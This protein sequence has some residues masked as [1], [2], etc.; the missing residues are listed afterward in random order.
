MKLIQWSKRR[1][2]VVPVRRFSSSSVA[3][4]FYWLMKWDTKGNECRELLGCNR[5]LDLRCNND[6]IRSTESSYHS[7]QDSRLIFIRFLL[8][9]GEVRRKI[10][11]YTFHGLMI[12]IVAHG[13]LNI[14]GLAVRNR[15]MPRFVC[16]KISVGQRMSVVDR[17]KIMPRTSFDHQRLSVNSNHLS[18]VQL[19]AT[20]D[21]T[22]SRLVCR[23]RVK[24][25]QCDSSRRWKEWSLPVTYLLASF[26]AHCHSMKGV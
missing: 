22:E 12:D 5:R 2:T 6:S 24:N 15:E 8:K 3:F 14:Q 4:L 10:L 18:D 20:V 23:C 19:W 13:C 1:N 26:P 7:K 17:G 16:V 21:H 11:F 25:D 9:I